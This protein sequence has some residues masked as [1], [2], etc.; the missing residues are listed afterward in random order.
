MG[1]QELE[2]VKDYEVEK[3]LLFMHFRWMIKGLSTYGENNADILKT[4]E[5]VHNVILAK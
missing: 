3:P 4:S 5:K 1:I 2:T